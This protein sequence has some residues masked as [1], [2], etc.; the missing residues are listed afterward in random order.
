[1]CYVKAARDV[2]DHV[3]SNLA[4]ET[5]AKNLTGQTEAVDQG[6][7]IDVRTAECGYT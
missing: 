7:L 1:V 2:Q 3:L 5:G 6:S 4:E